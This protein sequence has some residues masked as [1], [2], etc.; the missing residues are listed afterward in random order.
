MDV[1][2]ILPEL[3]SIQGLVL[4]SPSPENIIGRANE[5]IPQA[6]KVFYGET[7][8]DT[9]NTLDSIKY[10]L[11]V[12]NLNDV[13]KSMG[14]PT[15]AMILVADTAA[16]RNVSQNLQPHYMQLGTERANFVSRVNQVYNGGLR[17]V[18]MSDYINTPEFQG[19]VVRVTELCKSDPEL[20]KMVEESVPPSAVD[21]EREKEFM[22]SF[23]E[24]ATIL[25][26]DFKVGPPREDLYDRAARELARRMGKK[27]VMSIFLTPT[28]PLGLGWDYFFAH[29]D[30][31]K[32]GITAY[33]GASKR[34]QHYRV[35]VGRTSPEYAE[36]LIS[37]SFISTRQDVPNPVLD[38]GMIVEM[39]R[40]RLE[41]RIAQI[42]LHKRFYNGDMSPRA[43]KAYVSQGLKEY[44]LDKLV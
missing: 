38:I 18:R 3:L 29:E 17:V 14:Y 9:G 15:D 42:D 30:L 23:D 32:Y 22:Y 20:M 16:C 13:L 33:K 21:I 28:F 1:K 43:L 5:V 35:L 40:Q 44:I 27:Q 34:L 39:A 19:E 41:G 6:V 10:Y 4:E 11:F 37:N 26:L 24:L 2:V 7:Y 25:D 31:E 8:D 36:D 12:A